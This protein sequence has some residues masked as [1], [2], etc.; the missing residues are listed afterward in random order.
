MNA[1]LGQGTRNHWGS[2]TSSSPPQLPA[3]I[4]QSKQQRLTYS[5]SP[6]WSHGL[7]ICASSASLTMHIVSELNSEEYVNVACLALL[8]RFRISSFCSSVHR[9][10]WPEYMYTGAS[11]GA[12]RWPA[13]T[14][15]PSVLFPPTV[16]ANAESAP[17]ANFVLFIV[18]KS[19]D[20]RARSISSNVVLRVSIGPWRDSRD[21]LLSAKDSSTAIHK[22]AWDLSRH[23]LHSATSKFNSQTLFTF[24]G[25]GFHVLTT[26]L[27]NLWRDRGGPVHVNK[28]HGVSVLVLNIKQHRRGR[29][30]RQCL[31]LISPTGTSHFRQTVQRIKAQL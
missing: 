17:P 12:A 4:H 13:L 31:Q 16:D 23:N 2:S 8:S 26:S 25:D 3:N 19:L 6:H 1:P 15:C 14:E 20:P 29:E 9:S 24:G 30:E 7:T 27:R 28:C 11:L 18:T 21:T 5:V 22:G 10:F